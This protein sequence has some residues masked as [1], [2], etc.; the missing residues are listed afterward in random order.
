MKNVNTT[1]FAHF[2]FCDCHFDDTV[3]RGLWKSV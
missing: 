1:T 3:S 2:D